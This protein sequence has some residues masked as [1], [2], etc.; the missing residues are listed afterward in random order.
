MV[1]ANAPH[2]DRPQPVK[3]PPTSPRNL[4]LLSLE[5]IEKDEEGFTKPRAKIKSE[6]ERSSSPPTNISN[7]KKAPPEMSDLSMEEMKLM[8]SLQ[9]LEEVC[10]QQ[11]VRI[12]KNDIEWT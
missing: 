12:Q 4:P 11:K 7:R 3:I 8:Q 1:M 6:P 10:K 5:K 9:R 2:T